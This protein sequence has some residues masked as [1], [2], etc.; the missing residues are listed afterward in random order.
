MTLLNLFPYNSEITVWDK[1]DNI[2]LSRKSV[3][4][5]RVAD[6]VNGVAS[7]WYTKWRKE[8]LYG[9]KNTNEPSLYEKLGDAVCKKE[10]YSDNFK[11]EWVYDIEV[12]KDDWLFV[13]KSIDNQHKFVVWNDSEALREWIG[14]K[15][16]I[17]FNNAAYDDVV[18]R[19]IMAYPYIKDKS[20]TVKTFSDRLILDEEGPKYPEFKDPKDKESIVEPEV[21]FQELTKI[22]MGFK[23]IKNAFIKCFNRNGIIIVCM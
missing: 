4:P 6:R 5:E 14:N 16:L 21:A 7:E 22:I 23:E 10:G 1:S 3:Y 8:V 17:G 12:F 2:V 20:I 13:A 15:I 9:A 19:H 18:I 11:Y